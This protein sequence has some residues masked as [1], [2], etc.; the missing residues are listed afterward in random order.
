MKKLLIPS[1]GERGQDGAN[2]IPCLL[3]PQSD[4]GFIRY[5]KYKLVPEKGAIF[6]FY[7][8]PEKPKLPTAPFKRWGWS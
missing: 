2:L 5:W 7:R 1:S 6:V 3:E 8:I 4:Y